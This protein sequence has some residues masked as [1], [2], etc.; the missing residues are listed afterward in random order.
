MARRVFFSFHYEDV[1]RVNQVRNA[2][3]VVG[4]QD[5]GFYDHSEY[6]ERG[7]ASPDYIRRT[8][9]EKMADTTVT[10]ILIGENTAER[11]WVREEIRM[12]VER[13]N[14]LLGIFI[15]RLR[16][17]QDPRPLLYELYPTMRPPIPAVPPEVFFPTYEWDKDLDR[18]RQA[19]EDAG[20]RAD[21]QRFAYALRSWK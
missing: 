14:G 21:T 2:N 17:P 19:V 3:V 7:G 9:R 12:S 1:W 5:A 6:L 15:H 20:I 18:F 10:V 11:P 16:T 13:R 8:I 4:A